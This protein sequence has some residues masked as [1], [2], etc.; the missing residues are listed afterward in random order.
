MARLRREKQMQQ[1]S[2]CLPCISWTVACWVSDIRRTLL[3]KYAHCVI[4]LQFSPMY[5]DS[6]NS[7]LNLNT[8]KFPRLFS[9]AG[10][11]VLILMNKEN[12]YVLLNFDNWEW[13]SWDRRW[14]LRF[15]AH[16]VEHSDQSRKSC[17]ILSGILGGKVEERCGLWDTV[18]LPKF[19]NI[20]PLGLNL[21]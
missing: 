8:L 4:M 17:L 13:H 3:V 6:D 15:W 5:L 21:V 12:S 9:S 11:F 16:Q 19:W 7:A 18:V 2:F 20:W 14:I 1:Q 10:K